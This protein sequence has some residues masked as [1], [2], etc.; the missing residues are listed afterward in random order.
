MPT[1]PLH[2]DANNLSQGTQKTFDFVINILHQKLL[3]ILSKAFTILT[4]YEINTYNKSV[5]S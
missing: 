4:G 5:N 2:F 3:R 1:P